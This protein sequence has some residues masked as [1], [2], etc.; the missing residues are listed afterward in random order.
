MKLVKILIVLTVAICFLSFFLRSKA[1]QS[2]LKFELKEFELLNLCHCYE[3]LELRNLDYIEWGPNGRKAFLDD[4]GNQVFGRYLGVSLHSQFFQDEYDNTL[5][6]K[7]G[8]SKYQG[9]HLDFSHLDSLYYEPMVQY[10]VGKIKRTEKLP[11][12][13][14]GDVSAF[15]DCYHRVKE[16]PLEKEYKIFLKMNKVT[17]E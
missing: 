11:Y 15:F 2:S 14:F 6:F 3:Y 13:G 4:V 12:L 7:N 10:Y 17:K 8:Y 9:F 5:F 16:I 1:H